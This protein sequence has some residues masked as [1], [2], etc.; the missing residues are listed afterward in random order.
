MSAA[1]LTPSTTT[2]QS[3]PSAL[4]IFEARAA[5]RA[6]LYRTGEFGLHTAVD[7]L[8]YHAERHGLVAEIGQDQVQRIIS[9]VFRPARA[10][11][12]P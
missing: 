2:P 8:Q 5:A 7:E 6:Y 10:G 3:R 11:E 12:A 1:P 9:E 4:K